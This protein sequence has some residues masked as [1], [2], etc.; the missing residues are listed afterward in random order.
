M[1]LRLLLWP[2]SCLNEHSFISTVNHHIL[3]SFYTLFILQCN[4]EALYQWEVFTRE[5]R[6]V[7]DFRIVERESS[8]DSCVLTVVPLF[9]FNPTRRSR[10]NSGQATGSEMTT[11]MG[12]RDA[13][14]R[15]RA[16]GLRARGEPY[17]QSE[18]RITGLWGSWK[19]YTHRLVVK[20][21]K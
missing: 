8:S 11:R 19:P 17:A 18:S 15:E 20:T 16:L 6:S 12:R 3:V 14:I 13:C 9:L 4:E 5:K 10:T 1:L 21:E 7:V 2:N